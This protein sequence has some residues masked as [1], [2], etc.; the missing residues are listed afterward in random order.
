MEVWTPTVVVEASGRPATV[1]DGASPP[2]LVTKMVM[3][4]EER[5]TPMALDVKMGGSL[6][7]SP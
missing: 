7:R 6:T 1:V 5:T 2:D 4:R 3:K